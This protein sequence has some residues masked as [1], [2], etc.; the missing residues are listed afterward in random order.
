MKRDEAQD[1]GV[2]LRL[3]DVAEQL[4]GEHGVA[5][6]SV[7]AITAAAGL[8]V[9][10]IHYYFGS[11]ENLVREVVERRQRPLNAERL[12]L[13]D[14]C[15]T[16]SPPDVDAILHALAAPALRLG[17][18]QP[19]FARLASRLRLDP[20][21]SLWR[22]YRERQQDLAARFRQALAD[23]LPHLDEAEVAARLHFVQGAILHVW[24]HCPVPPEESPALL[25][26]RFLTF[27]AAAL[28]APGSPLPPAAEAA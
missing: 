8:N 27:Y 13:L 1:T 17:C 4:F 9:A 11:K 14:A 21:R 26:S 23:T 7:R 10:L 18:E 3:L 2:R 15:R 6:T 24:A 5:E 12:R 22:D 16:G 20:D 28:R 25:L 19:H